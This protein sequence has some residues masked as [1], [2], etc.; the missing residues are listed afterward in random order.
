MTENCCDEVCFT[1]LKKCFEKKDY[2]KAWGWTESTGHGGEHPYTPPSPWEYDPKYKDKEGEIGSHGGSSDSIMTLVHLRKLIYTV[3]S[4][5]FATKKDIHNVKVYIDGEYK[6]ITSAIMPTLT[7]DLEPN[8]T[9]SIRLEAPGYKT[10][11][12]EYTTGTTPATVTKTLEK[13]KAVGTLSVTSTPIGASV[14]LT[15]PSGAVVPVTS[16]TTPLNVELPVG[17]YDL[18]IS[19]SGYTEIKDIITITDG[20]T[21]TK[22]YTLVSAGVRTTFSANAPAKLYVNGAYKGTLS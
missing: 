5:T 12:F 10:L 13:E 22:N 19:K 21:I 3:V 17:V 4:I 11:S 2:K 16:F 6:G 7:V 9:Y 18:V 1:E 20:K 14:R 8:T 15:P